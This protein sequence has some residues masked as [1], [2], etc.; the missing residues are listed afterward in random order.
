MSSQRASDQARRPEWNRHSLEAHANR[1]ILK[2]TRLLSEA[3]YWRHEKSQTYSVASATSSLVYH[4]YPLQ[5]KGGSYNPWWYQWGCTCEAGE[6]GYPA[7]W[8]KALIHISRNDGAAS[9]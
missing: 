1:A 8:H 3:R 5:S 9:P 7:C 2:A 6:N 4:V